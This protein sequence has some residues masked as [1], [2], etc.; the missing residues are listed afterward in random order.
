M[1][2]KVLITVNTTSTYMYSKV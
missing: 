1:Y 2:S